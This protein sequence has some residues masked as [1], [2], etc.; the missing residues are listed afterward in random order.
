MKSEAIGEARQ[1][2][3]NS[4]D[5]PNLE[6]LA[7]TEAQ[8]AQRLPVLA[9]HPRRRCAHFFGDMTEHANARRQAGQF[10]PS[11]LFDRVDQLRVPAFDTQKLCVGLRSVMAV[12]CGR[13]SRSDHLALGTAQASRREHHF[14][15]QRAEGRTDSRM[16]A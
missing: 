2:I 11:M 6:H 9:R 8:V 15:K 13:R 14:G 3:E 10:A 4:D 7:V 16:R 12:L 5:M 1:K